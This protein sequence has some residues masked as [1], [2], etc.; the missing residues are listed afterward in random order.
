[1]G[2]LPKQLEQAWKV[3]HKAAAEAAFAEAAKSGQKVG[4]PSFFA[5]TAA[6]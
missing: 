1:M 5:S 6:E 2:D 3:R 4:S